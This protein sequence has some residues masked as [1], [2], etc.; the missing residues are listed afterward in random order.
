M[1]TAIRDN[2]PVYIMENTLLYGTKGPVPDPAD[3]D[4]LVPLGKADIK[5]EGTDV[6]LIAHGRSVIRS[7]EAAETLQPNTVSTVRFSTC[8]LFVHSI[9]KRSS[10]R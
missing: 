1:K 7:L 5:R 9:S 2:D 6:S 4:H 8:A 10:I 3:G